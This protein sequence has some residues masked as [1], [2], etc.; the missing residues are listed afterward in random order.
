VNVIAGNVPAKA[1]GIHAALHA[2]MQSVE[3][4]GLGR[5]IAKT[6][7]PWA[8]P[9]R[10]QTADGFILLSQELASPMPPTPWELLKTNAGLA[11]N[12][13]FAS[14]SDGAVSLRAEIPETGEC[15][16]ATRLE[17]TSRDFTTALASIN[18][19]PE[20]SNAPAT[21]GAA[22][23]LPRLCEQAGWPCSSHRAD[24]CV[25][26]L[27]TRRAAHTAQLAS[28]GGGVRVSTELASW[29]SLAGPCRESLSVFLLAANTLLRLA[30][31][32]VTEDESGGAAPLEVIIEAPGSAAELCSALE[33]LSVGAD[34]CAPVADILQQ[35]EAAKHFLSIRWGGPRQLERSKPTTER[36]I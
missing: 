36:K 31:A 35:E 28:Q 15:D 26:A 32:V 19:R 20:N 25:V 8:P 11:G 16:L 4:I 29:E 13:K 27:D 24:R 10:V 22:P 34:L 9:L 33:A 14:D 21:E 1:S 2:A 17:R 5:W 12:L 3:A 7:D 18:A 23:D 30:R 6:S